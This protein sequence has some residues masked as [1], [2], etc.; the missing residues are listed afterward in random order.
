MRLDVEG[1]APATTCGSDALRSAE[2]TSRKA[3]DPAFDRLGTLIFRRAGCPQVGHDCRSDA[4]A[5]GLMTS[6]VLH[7]VHRYS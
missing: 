5:M 6:K 2:S 3:D 7:A 1:N 4:A